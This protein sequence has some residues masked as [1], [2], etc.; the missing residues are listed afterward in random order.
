M[1]LNVSCPAVCV[2][3]LSLCPSSVIPP[4]CQ[5]GFYCPDGTCKSGPNEKEA[6]KGAVPICSC[7]YGFTQSINSK[8]QVP[9][10]PCSINY[11]VNVRNYAQTHILGDQ[12]LIDECISS[13]KLESSSKV[14]LGKQ[15]VIL[16]CK[17]KPLRT[18]TFFEAGII[19]H[20][21]LRIFGILFNHY[22]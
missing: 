7:Q 20:L 15:P 5:N 8:T 6:C 10:Y 21:N 2:P 11:T 18:I 9:L 17:S 4:S 19:L 13:L 16:D 12:P 14:T 22:Y 1:R 3:D